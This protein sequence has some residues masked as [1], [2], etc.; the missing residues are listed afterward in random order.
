MSIE[1]IIGLF[2][3][4]ASYDK[5]G[6]NSKCHLM[7]DFALLYG[8]IPIRTIAKKI[9]IINNYI[10]QGFNLIPILDYKLDE[11]AN[12]NDY[13]KQNPNAVYQDGWT[14]Q[15]RAPGHELHPYPQM[16]TIDSIED[17]TQSYDDYLSALKEYKE[18]IKEY[19]NASQEQ[20]TKFIVDYSILEKSELLI[21][22]SKATNFFYDAN[23]GFSF[24]DINLKE[25]PSFVFNEDYFTGYII[26]NLLS[27]LPSMMTY[28][29]QYYRRGDVDFDRVIPS[30]LSQEIKE[31]LVTLIDK[32]VIGLNK[33]GISKQQIEKT[34][35]DIYENYFSSIFKS[36]EKNLTYEDACKKVYKN[37][38]TIIFNNGQK[39][40]ITDEESS[41]SNGIFFR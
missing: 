22:S 37:L 29:K 7:G 2:K 17:V 15:K 38:N 11:T 24:I 23:T 33:A 28:Q 12:I 31:L 14:L 21:D 32:I 13:S 10:K 39:G 36:Q 3:N 27:N 19:A 20:I 6:S 26:N 5:E 9:E 30:D 40:I 1:E 18:R 34:I 35:I 8:S 16:I 41:K 25:N 4:N